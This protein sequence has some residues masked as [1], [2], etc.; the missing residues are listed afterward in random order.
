MQSSPKYGEIFKT[1]YITSLA[2]KLILHLGRTQIIALAQARISS[3][4]KLCRL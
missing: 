3:S 2:N 1:Y 4:R